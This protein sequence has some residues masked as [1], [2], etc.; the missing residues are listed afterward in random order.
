[1][2]ADPLQ[3]CLLDQAPGAFRD[4]GSLQAAWVL[5]RA[6]PTAMP[7]SW[8]PTAEAPLENALDGMER[9]PAGIQVPH[10]L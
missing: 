5:R 2:I 9:L 1:M 8:A 10:A 6:A 4:G 7:I 3:P